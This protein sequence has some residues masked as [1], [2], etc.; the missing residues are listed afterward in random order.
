MVFSKVE[1]GPSPAELK[2]RENTVSG[3]QLGSTT[4]CFSGKSLHI[5]SRKRRRKA[6]GIEKIVIQFYTDHI[7]LKALETLFFLEKRDEGC[8]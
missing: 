7:N 1:N 2:L 6:L 3:Y 4:S 5:H 8:L